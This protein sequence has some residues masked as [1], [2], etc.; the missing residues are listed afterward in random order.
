MF[1][2]VMTSKIDFLYQFINDVLSVV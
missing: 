1:W 2:P